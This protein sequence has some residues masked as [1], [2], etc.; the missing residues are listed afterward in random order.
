MRP[1]TKNAAMVPYYQ[2][3]EGF[4]K[5]SHRNSCDYFL[6]L[7]MWV[8]AIGC[9]IGNKIPGEQKC[10]FVNLW[11]KHRRFDGLLQYG[12][13]VRIAYTRA[14]IVQ[15]DT[16]HSCN[17]DLKSRTGTYLTLRRKFNLNLELMKFLFR[18]NEDQKDYLFF[19]YLR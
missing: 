16:R 14:S 4:S 9:S 10:N 19:S 13:V 15:D 17:V 3:L 8:R 7:N 12:N 18:S 11:H 1:N 2:Y 5:Q 6:L